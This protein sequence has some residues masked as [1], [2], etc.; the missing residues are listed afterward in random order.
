MSDRLA[1]MHAGRIEQL[2]PPKEVYEQPDTTFVASFLG[3]SNLLIG[4]PRRRDG[5]RCTV[6][7]GEFE[8]R[9]AGD[10]APP[11][12]GEA[13][14][15]IRP[16]RVRIEPHDAAG[17]NRVPALIERVVYRGSADQ[18]FARL[19]GGEQVQ[20]LVQNAGGPTYGP[21]DAVR[22]HLPADGLRVLADTGGSAIESDDGT[23]QAPGL[24]PVGQTEEERSH[25]AGEPT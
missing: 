14:L 22:L 7:F 2:G 10:A 23:A 4:A 16:E 20:A 11:A 25:A 17:E 5:D 15:I 1:V 9:V 24:A 8:L 19:P 18:V 6:Q 21:G 13:Q 3:I 12:R